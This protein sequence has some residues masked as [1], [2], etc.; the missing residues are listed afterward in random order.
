M[1]AKR[2]SQPPPAGSTNLA[3]PTHHLSSPKYGFHTDVLAA[4]VINAYLDKRGPAD[5][6]HDALG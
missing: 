3:D 5:G 6:H 4:V 2:R 1:P